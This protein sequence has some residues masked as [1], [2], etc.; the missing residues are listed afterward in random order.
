M[1][2][3]LLLSVIFSG[4]FLFTN[5]QSQ[6][7]DWQNKAQSFLQKREY[8]FKK[9]SPSS[10]TCANVAQH[11]VYQI[12]DRGYCVEP[13][14]YT[15]NNTGDT[16]SNSFSVIRISKGKTSFPV[17]ATSK[18]SFKENYLLQDHGSYKTEYINNEDGLRQNFIIAS[19]PEGN[20]NLDVS[21]QLQAKNMSVNMLND[22]ALVFTEANKKA[23]IKYDGLKVWD[24]AG[25][26]LKAH[27]QLSANNVLD[28]IAE[29]KDAVYPITI[30][31]LNHTS[32]W[33]GTAQGILPSVIGQLAIDALYGFSVAGVGDVNGDG[34]ADIAIGAPGM[35]DVISGT[36]EM[37][38]VGA[39]FVYY[40]SKNGLSVTPD[41]EMQP[42]TAIAG[43]LFGFSI[44]GGDINNDGRSDIIVG[45]PLDKIT[46]STGGSGTVGRVYVFNGSNLTS[47]ATAPLLTLQLSGMNIIQN[48][49]N[50]N[51]NALFGFSVAVTDDMNNDGKKDI[52]VGSP[53]YLG[54]NVTT[55]TI[56]LLG[57]STTYTADVQ[58]GG[59]FLFLSQSSGT[60]YSLQKLNPPTTSLLGLGLLSSN[61]SGLLFGYSVDGVGDY[62]GDG[63]TDIAI[64]APAGI[65]LS[66]ISSLLSGKLLQG[67][68]MVYYG[69]GSGAGNAPG[70]TLVTSNGGLI[71]NLSGTLSNLVNLFG[72]SVKGVKNTAGFHTGNIIVGAPLGGALTNLLSGLQVKTGTVS[73]FV[74]NPGASGSIAPNQQ[75]S[76]P[77]NSN[78]ILNLV[79]S[80]LLFGYSIDNA[81]DMNC[82]GISD[83]VIGEPASSGAQLIGANVA[84]GSAYI[85][86]GNSDGTYQTN[87]GWTL[88]ATYD[89]TL[90]VN[91]ASLIGYSV[92]GAGK[93]KGISGTSKVL[94]GSPA[95][96]LD[97]GTGLLNL[98]NTL[99]TLFGLAAGDNGIGKSYV[100]DPQICSSAQ[101]LPLIITDFNA[102]PTIDNKVLISWKVS[103]ERNVNAYIIERSTNGTTWENFGLLPASPNSDT[104]TSFS[105]TDNHPYS[106][107]SYYRIKQEDLDNGF[108]YTTIKAVDFNTN[109]AGR[110]TVN[111]PFNSFITIQLS[112]TQNNTAEIQL[113]DLTGKLI[114]RQSSAVAAGINT[115]QVNDLSSLSKGMY[116]VR[117]ISGSETYSTKLI[118]Q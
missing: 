3:F 32:E 83:L 77:R 65:D 96:T 35:P 94:I 41:V 80:N 75:L 109:I 28:I 118:K 98:G 17:E 72:L 117:I 57:T 74:K 15:E 88:S 60:N 93:V 66:S 116:L 112:S 53:A 54:I 81:N 14:R 55:I 110:V 31:P 105:L 9:S 84:G 18:N 34:Y 16:W 27:M 25:K 100:Y 99:G 22:D 45:A 59:A 114:R 2:H 79:Q 43:A 38:A 67:S 52:L 26:I 49:I 87:P 23:T 70:A 37:L 20:K 89:P 12:N 4:C 91:A 95:R 13:M 115:F 64:G 19:K 48:G 42:S 71:T 104:A 111:N 102:V 103:T 78:N 51:V 68:V 56:P 73:V 24:A 8:F 10:F 61:V 62:N 33:S 21:I 30:D 7:E 69:N 86:F 29:D 11:V 90:G 1:K 106:G 85:Y 40:G 63:Y 76:S 97:F 47:V 92:A 6:Q 50:L 107:I 46:L 101:S 36:G 108:F 58:S 44:A 113:Y 82:D 5:A 39:V